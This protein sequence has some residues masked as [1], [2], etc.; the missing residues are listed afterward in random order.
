MSKFLKR[1]KTIEDIEKDESKMYNYLEMNQVLQIRDHILND[2][3][4][5]KA[6]IRILIASIL[7]V[8]ALTGMRIGE[9]TST[10]GRR[11]RFIKQN[12][13]YNS[14]IHRIKYEEGFLYKDTTKTISSKR[15]ISINS[16]TVEIFKKD[17]TGKQNV[18]KMEFELC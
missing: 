12:Y 6:K 13:Q 18:E 7:E 11:Y 2:N 8:Q 10:A 1:R 3:K 15:S 16:R 17:N 9:T 14:R 5:H 4:L